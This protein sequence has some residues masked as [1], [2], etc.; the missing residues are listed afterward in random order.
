MKTHGGTPHTPEICKIELREISDYMENFIAN[1]VN[2]RVGNVNRK[3]KHHSSIIGTPLIPISLSN[4]A[5]PVLYI[6]LGIVL[7]LFEMI[8]SEVRKLDCNH[9]PEV[10]KVIEQKWK[11]ESK[12]LKEKNNDMYKLCDKLLD[13]INIK[14]RFTAKLENNISE[15]DKVAKICSG[16][17]KKQKIQPCSGFLCLASQFDNK[18]EWVQCDHGED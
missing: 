14:E 12:K 9:I 16:R 7:K 4:I 18:L 15:L 3:G 1:V 17:A 13:L 2:D 11:A 6:T 10:Q 8:L 5:P